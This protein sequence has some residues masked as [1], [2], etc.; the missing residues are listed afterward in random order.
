M[1]NEIE[2]KGIEERI[3]S[4]EMDI[5]WLKNAQEKQILNV[6]DIT[7]MVGFSRQTLYRS[8]EY[9]LPLN[10]LEGVKE[11]TRSE[12]LEHLSRPLDELKAEY[13]QYI[14]EHKE[15]LIARGREK[16]KKKAKAGKKAKIKSA[17]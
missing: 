11:W 14:E 1:E 10:H 13:E 8:R 5:H 2:K 12:I 7:R 9:L 3:S 4:I 6:S 15:E 17:S 16:A